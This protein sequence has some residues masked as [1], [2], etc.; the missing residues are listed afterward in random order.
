MG[1]QF[2]ELAQD[3]YSGI[4]DYA[5]DQLTGDK[6]Q[7]KI[8]AANKVLD[9]TKTISVSAY[10]ISKDGL[11]A[12]DAKVNAQLQK[13]S[14]AIEQREADRL[15]ALQD[16]KDEAEY[17]SEKLE[18]TEHDSYDPYNDYEEDGNDLSELEE[19]LIEDEAKERSKKAYEK[20]ERQIKLSEQQ[21]AEDL[22]IRTAIEVIEFL[23]RHGDDREVDIS[24]LQQGT[25][26]KDL[27]KELETK[28]DAKLIQ[29]RD[30]TVSLVSQKEFDKK[31]KERAVELE[32]LNPTPTLE[33]GKK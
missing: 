6:L 22:R 15:Q 17:W 23:K 8:D 7:S 26:L 18:D 10:K 3:V 27:V 21:E 24:K 30:K 19:D 14:D 32:K 4:K 33:R 11:Y 1:G 9:K 28:Y 16:A 25:A 2:S 29:R 5:V 12:A 20:L 13:W 31:S